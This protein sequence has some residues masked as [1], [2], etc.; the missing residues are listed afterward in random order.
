MRRGVPRSDPRRSALPLLIFGGGFPNRR[1]RPG[2]RLVCALAC[3]PALV[4][5]AKQPIAQMNPTSSRATAVITIGALFVSPA[6]AYIARKV[7]LAPSM[8]WSGFP[9]GAPR[10]DAACPVPPSQTSFSYDRQVQPRPKL[11][12]WKE[13][14]SRACASAFVARSRSPQLLENADQG[15]PLALGYE[16]GYDAVRRYAGVWAKTKVSATA[17]AFAFS[18][19]PP[20]ALRAMLEG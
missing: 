16:G 1:R 20:D 13:D 10:A 2:H 4:G 6:F 19:W 18:S 7:G 9:R 8:R 14:L 11:G 5:E 15:Q 12:K 3:R 17:N